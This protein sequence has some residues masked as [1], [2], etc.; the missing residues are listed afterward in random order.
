[1]SETTKDNVE[2]VT[3]RAYNIDIEELTA[4]LRDAA[5]YSPYDYG[6]EAHKKGRNAID[7]LASLAPALAARV[8]ADAAVLREARTALEA[9]KKQ[10][11]E[12]PH[13]KGAYCFS[14]CGAAALVR[15]AL[16]KLEAGR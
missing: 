7:E 8:V 9:A 3:R 11:A 15:T 1:M 12:H 5:G 13:A 2:R 4:L 10:L 14:A 6:S 16:D